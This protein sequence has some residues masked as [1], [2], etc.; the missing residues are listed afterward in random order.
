MVK[1][2]CDDLKTYALMRMNYCLSDAPEGVRKIRLTKQ[3]SQIYRIALSSNAVNDSHL[4]TQTLRPISGRYGE[5]A[6]LKSFNHCS[7]N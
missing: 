1:L 2:I 4:S 3:L 5:W 6:R 7:N